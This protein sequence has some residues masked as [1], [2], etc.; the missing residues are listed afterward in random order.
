MPDP[1]LAG[2]EYAGRPTFRWSHTNSIN[3]AYPAFQLRI[4]RDAE[5]RSIVYDSGIQRAPARDQNGMYRWTAPVYADMATI[6]ETNGVKHATLFT[7]T[8]NYYWS[9]SML[10]AKFTTFSPKETVTPFRLSTSGSVADGKEHGSI[11]VRVK[12]FGALAEKLSDKTTSMSTL[13]NLIHVQAFTTPDFSGLPVAETYVTNVSTIASESVIATNAVLRGVECGGTYYVR[14]YIDTDADG[15]KSDWESWG[16]NCYVADNSIKEVYAPRPVKVDYSL[17]PSPVATVFI[18]DAD[19]ENDGFP[20]AWEMYTYGNLTDQEPVTGNTFFA[21]VNPELKDKVDFYLA[22]TP[23]EKVLKYKNAVALMAP[24]GSSSAPVE[25]TAVQISKFSLEGGL[26]LEVVNTTSGGDSS[27]IITF[28]KEATV[29]LSLMCATTPDFSDAV[30]V[31]VKKF[32]I[33]S[34]DTTVEAVTA[35]ELAEARAKAPEARFFKAIIKQ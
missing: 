3:K 7:T 35:E 19:I 25:T 12:Y 24:A 2:I 17:N 18:E 20:D 9:V 13:T 33:R 14:A 10:D 28:S 1:K 16:Y 11:V 34:N 29:N 26:E 8:N 30:E 21:T 15:V 6:W 31:P 5:K 32:T 23:I 4:Y 22:G 27:S